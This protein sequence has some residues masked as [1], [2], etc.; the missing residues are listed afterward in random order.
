V[1]ATDTQGFSGS[2][3]FT[4]SIH[5]A[6]GTVPN[7]VGLRLGPAQTALR[8]AGFDSGL[9]NYVDDSTC[10]K[11]GKVISQSPVG[12]TVTFQGSLVSLTV[13]QMPPDRRGVMTLRGRSCPAEGVQ[14][15][16][17]I[18]GLGRADPLEDLLGLPQAGL[19]VGGVASGLGAAA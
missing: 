5:P 11:I 6:M 3:S 7:V 17:D 4:W 14:F 1:T 12:G 9:I 10:T 8:A 19:R 16:G 18:G 13:W 2:S 15:G